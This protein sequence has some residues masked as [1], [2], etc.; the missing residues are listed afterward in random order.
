MSKSTQESYDKRIDRL[1]KIL[2]LLKD[3]TDDDKTQLLNL[4]AQYLPPFEEVGRDVDLKDKSLDRAI[5]ATAGLVSWPNG[6]HLEN[7]LIK[8]QKSYNLAIKH[9]YVSLGKDIEKIGR[10]IRQLGEK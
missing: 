8:E 6:C 5:Y 4:P 10:I 2:N 3:K 9:L 1:D 7:G